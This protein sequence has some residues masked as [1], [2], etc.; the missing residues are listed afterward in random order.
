ML[1]ELLPWQVKV[2]E[3]AVLQMLDPHYYTYLRTVSDVTRIPREVCRGVLR[4]LVDQGMA[5]YSKG[6][7]SEDGHVAGS[8]YRLTSKG[9]KHA[10]S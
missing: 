9:K 5:E 3:K 8:G 2:L 7:F 4:G 1:T 6:L 10:D